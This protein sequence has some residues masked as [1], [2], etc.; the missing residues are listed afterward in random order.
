MY[1]QP[2]KFLLLIALAFG[3]CQTGFAKTWVVQVGGSTG[4]GGEYG[5]GYST[6]TL[7]FSPTPLTINAGDSVTFTNLGG[8]AHNVHADDN[9]FR[10]ANGC[11]GSGGNGNPASNGWQFTLTFS[12][13]GTINYHCDQHVSMG[14]VGSIVVNAVAP[15]PVALGGYMSGNWF[16]PDQSGQGFELE[17]TGQPSDT[18]G[19][20]ALVAYW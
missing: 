16:N 4:G 6:P 1:I 11:D 10:C 2:R 5:G 8:A 9:S 18:P 15:P 17:F 12:T 14:M 3:L 20:N 7:A 19:Q 13:P